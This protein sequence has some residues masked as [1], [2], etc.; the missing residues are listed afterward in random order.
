MLL[1]S[2]SDTNHLSRQIVG[3][4]CHEILI[5]RCITILFLSNFS[6]SSIQL[7]FWWLSYSHY[8]FQLISIHRS[9]H[10]S[11][12]AKNHQSWY[13][14][15]FIS[16]SNGRRA[17]IQRHLW[18]FEQSACIYCIDSAPNS[19]SLAKSEAPAVSERS[20]KYLPNTS[21]QRRHKTMTV[22]SIDVL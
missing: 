4:G 10:H 5:Q 6:L 3:C 7:W 8:S 18:S 2:H 1:L 16:I 17:H 15:P 19:H 14:K 22:I 9:V 11:D 13:Q 20:E 12:S 21:K